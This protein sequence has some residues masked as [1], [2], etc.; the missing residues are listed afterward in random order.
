MSTRAQSAVPQTERFL[1]FCIGEL[2][3]AVRRQ[4][5]R[6]VVSLSEAEAP[7]TLAVGSIDYPVVDPR[8][9]FGLAPVRAAR[10]IILQ[11]SRERPS[12][13]VV[14]RV[15][16][17]LVIDPRRFQSIPWHFGGREQLW[18]EGVAA[19]DDRRPLV[20]LR[21][22]GLLASLGAQTSSAKGP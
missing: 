20:L 9:L 14:D 11:V 19:L 22:Q 4:T 5:V 1:T 8:G 10:Q 21:P 2:S 13:L 3:Y 12:A 7:P 18:F 15:E 6:D 17:L 16:D